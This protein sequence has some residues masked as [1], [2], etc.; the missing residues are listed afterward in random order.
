MR[1]INLRVIPR[2]RQ[3]KIDVDSDGNYRL[4]TNAVP[5]DG[6]ANVAIVRA[7]SEYLKIPKSRIKIVRGLAARDK[8]IEISE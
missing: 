1:R 8:V 2:A 7:L 5:V 4:H 3:N 6:A